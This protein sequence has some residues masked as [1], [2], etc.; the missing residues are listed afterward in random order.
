M[1][2]VPVR[3]S[4]KIL[5]MLLAAI[6]V[7]I[8]YVYLYLLFAP[9][10][11][12]LNYKMLIMIAVMVSVIMLMTAS[13]TNTLLKTLTRFSPYLVMLGATL[14]LLLTVLA[15]PT[16]M[17]SAFNYILANALL[18]NS[19]WVMAWIILLPLLILSQGFLRPLP[20]DNRLLAAISFFW[21]F[22][23][24]IVYFKGGYRLSRWD[25]ANR[26]LLHIFPLSLYYVI[27]KFGISTANDAEVGFARSHGKVPVAGS[28]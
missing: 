2:T 23:L 10:G 28:G 4:K 27:L 16:N 7:I 9:A 20:L 26:M 1:P 8:W 11:M 18:G 14:L 6:P 24:G 5:A 25:S 12:F 21:I 13:Q 19:G 17:G 22:L 15:K 3:H